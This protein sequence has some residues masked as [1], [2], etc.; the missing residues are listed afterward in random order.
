MRNLRGSK[1]F[2]SLTFTFLCASGRVQRSNRLPNESLIM[3]A[4]VVPSSEHRTASLV[5][6]FR[7][8]WY[9]VSDVLLKFRGDFQDFL[10]GGHF[11]ALEKALE[12][13]TKVNNKLHLKKRTKPV[14]PFNSDQF[15]WC[16]LL[17]PGKVVIAKEDGDF[18]QLEV[19]E[20]A[21]GF[22]HNVGKCTAANAGLGIVIGKGGKNISIADAAS[23]MVGLTCPIWYQTPGGIVL[24]SGMILKTVLDDAPELLKMQLKEGETLLASGDLHKSEVAAKVS[25]ASYLMQLE[26]G[27]L[28]ILPAKTINNLRENSLGVVFEITGF[29]MNSNMLF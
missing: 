16:Q 26:A 20:S 2:C 21:S 9:R 7:S 14:E 8:Q 22:M 11:E 4:Y 5:F 6:N 3:F 13:V 23:N 29:G 1:G 19:A 12:G 25:E 27:D 18:E 28:I 15:G 24:N 10:S 17:R